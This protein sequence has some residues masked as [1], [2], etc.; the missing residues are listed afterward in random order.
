MD[1]Y[2][3]LTWVLGKDSREGSSQCHIL[4]RILVFFLLYNFKKSVSRVF[5]IQMYVSFYEIDTP[6]FILKNPETT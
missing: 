1:P 3:E 2:G 4:V 6:N 5:E